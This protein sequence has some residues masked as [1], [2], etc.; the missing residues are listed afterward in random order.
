LRWEGDTQSHFISC[1]QTA[2]RN[3][4]SEP[5]TAEQN[6]NNEASQNVSSCFHKEEEVKGTS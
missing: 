1:Y 2:V 4:R 5:A 6:N 3:G